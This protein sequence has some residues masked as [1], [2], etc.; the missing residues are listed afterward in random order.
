M[1]MSQRPLAGQTAFV[2]G[3]TAGIGMAIVQALL[4]DGARVILN[5]RQPQAVQAAVS[6]LSWENAALTT[7]AVYGRCA[8]TAMP[9]AADTRS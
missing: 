9:S 7:A 1:S 4:A 2:S 8:P 6:R 5:G 3:S